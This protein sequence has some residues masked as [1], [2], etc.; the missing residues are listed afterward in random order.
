KCETNRDV[1]VENSR[2]VIFHKFQSTAFF[3][4][5]DI[6]SQKRRL[7]PRIRISSPVPMFLI[8]PEVS[9]LKSRHQSIAFPSNST[10]YMVKMK[11]C[12]KNIRN[13]IPMEAMFGQRF[14]KRI[15]MVNI[16]MAKELFRL[17]VTQTSI[18]QNKLIT[19]LDQEQPHRPCAQI[20]FISR[21]RL[22]P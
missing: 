19:V 20:I 15:G 10:P 18:Y 7:F 22:A 11:M 5:N 12:K 3:N 9:V 4:R 1:R 16:I 17:F 8:A 13:I 6:F 2:I 14:I 21:I